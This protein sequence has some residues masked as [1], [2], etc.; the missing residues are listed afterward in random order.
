[1]E[2]KGLLRCGFCD[3]ALPV[4]WRAHTHPLICRP[5]FQHVSCLLLKEDGFSAFVGFVLEEIKESRAPSICKLNSNPLRLASMCQGYR[6]EGDKSPGSFDPFSVGHLI[7]GCDLSL[8]F[9]GSV[10]GKNPNS[11]SWVKQ[12]LRR[13]L[14]GFSRA[15]VTDDAAGL[16]RAAPRVFILPLF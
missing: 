10:C 13:G 5:V 1:M 14:V 7:I 12:R 6:M 11:L 4:C 3:G 16:W 15:R 8:L 2:T 9:I